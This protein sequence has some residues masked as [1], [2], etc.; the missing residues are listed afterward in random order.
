MPFPAWKRRL[1]IL[2]T[3]ADWFTVRSVTTVATATLTVGTGTPDA[4]IISSPRDDLTNVSTQRLPKR[5]I[6]GFVL[7]RGP[8]KSP[9]TA[10]PATTTPQQ[11]LTAPPP[12]TTPVRPVAPP[13]PPGGGHASH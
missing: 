12:P 8:N 2:L 6:R 7:G 5:L 4:Q 11:E 10:K 9:N 3:S 13:R 1:K